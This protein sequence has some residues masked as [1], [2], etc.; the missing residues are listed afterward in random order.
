MQKKFPLISIYD[1]N[2][3]KELLRNPEVVSRAH[4]LAFALSSTKVGV[5]GRVGSPVTS[6]VLTTLTDKGGSAVGLS[7][8]GNNSEHEKAYRLPQ[9]SF[10]L[11][12]VGRGA[13]AADL[14]ALSS[15]QGV[16]ISGSDE[17]SLLG[18]LGYIGDKA[19]PIGIFTEENPNDVRTRISAHYINLMPHIH[20]S[21]DPNSLVHEVALEMRR[22][23]L[24]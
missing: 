10:P 3:E 14:V 23:N 15:S 17:E 6:T 8:A 24:K 1:A 21:K 9:V 11:V 2:S 13:L 18:I 16:I 4:Q 22:Q 20:I 5:I 19:V 12:Y 7:P